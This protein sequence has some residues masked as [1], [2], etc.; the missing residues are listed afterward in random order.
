MKPLHQKALFRLAVL[1][2]LASRERFAHGELAQ[3]IRE[4]AQKNYHIPNSQHVHISEKTIESWYYQWL[5][6]GIEGLIP[7]VRN[8]RGQSKIPPD[9]QTAIIACKKENPKR[10]LKTIQAHLESQGIATKGQLTRSSIHRLLQHHGLSRPTQAL[11]AIERRGFDALYANE[12]WYGDVMHGPCFSIDGK[13]RKVYLVSLMDDASRLIIH[14]AFC[15]G[16]KAVDIEGVLKQG[17]LKR[18]LCRKLVIDNGSAYR[19]GSLQ[20]ICARLD[21]RLIYCRPYEPESKGKLERWHRVVHQQFVSEL[22][23][24]KIASLADINA[25]LWAWIDTIYHQREHSSLD[26]QTPLARFQ[27]DLPRH[28]TLGLLANHL[29]E[30]FYHREKRAVKKDGTISFN[31]HCYEV[32]YTLSGQQVTVVFDPHE[33][34][35]LYVESLKD[36]CCLGPATP[37]DRA[38]NNNRQRV[39]TTSE[40]NPAASKKVAPPEDSIVEHALQDQVRSLGEH[41]LQSIAEQTDTHPTKAASSTVNS[42]DQAD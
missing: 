25:R 9:L 35:V 34:K 31:S 5:K 39:R 17:V 26:K 3:I 30:I 23:D 21:I 1:G 11:A 7:K 33:K 41:A 38:A 32:D 14:S 13:Q 40:N 20:G 27:Q 37:V 42:D 28:R 15:L 4:L 2:P 8:D 18:G 10:S 36:G 12:T 22:V 6:G 29:N 24:E 16:E 19:A